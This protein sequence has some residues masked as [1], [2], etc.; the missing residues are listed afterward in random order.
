MIRRRT[1]RVAICGGGN[2]AHALAGILGAD[3]RYLVRVL[4][5]RPALWNTKLRV[6]R[7]GKTDLVGSIGVVS[8]E[9][10]IVI[11]DSDVVLIAVP[12]YA[13]ESILTA[14]KPYVAD[15]SWVGSLP[16]SGG[17]GWMAK[18]ILK[19]HYKIGRAHV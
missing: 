3:S 13:K 15:D 18:S 19:G 7:E 9:P 16:G 12:A 5:R 14:I 2:L 10:R 4:T 8:H 17:F 6:V 1:L 11:P